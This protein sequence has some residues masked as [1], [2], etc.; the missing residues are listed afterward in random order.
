[1]PS[2]QT[3]WVSPRVCPVM[4]SSLIALLHWDNRIKAALSV[5]HLQHPRP[6]VLLLL[7]LEKLFLPS[8]PFALEEE[9]KTT[10]TKKEREQ[11]G[12]QI[13]T[14]C[15]RNERAKRRWERCCGQGGR[16]RGP[17]S[18]RSR[19]RGPTAPQRRPGSQL[20]SGPA[21]PPG[22]LPHRPAQGA[23]GG[24]R[25][26]PFSPQK[27]T[28]TPPTWLSARVRV[29]PPEGGAA[30]G[31]ALRLSAQKQPRTTTGARRRAPALLPT[32]TAPEPRSPNSA[33]EHRTRKVGPS[34]GA[35]TAALLFPHLTP[36]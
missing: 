17:H 23:A 36:D 29:V 1:M 2:Q 10:T 28:R 32:P 25:R 18:Q 24:E 35:G 34:A 11:Q 20:L 3:L 16:R 4:G 5:T 13:G 12:A 27:N 7:C 26:F 8:E 9:K 31:G 19:R 15:R 21:E 33:P 30:A 14:K 22:P 6:A